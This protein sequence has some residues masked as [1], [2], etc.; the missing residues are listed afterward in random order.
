MSNLSASLIQA[1]RRR[2]PDLPAIGISGYAEDAFRRKL[3]QD[4]LTHFLPKPFNLND[5]ATKVKEVMPRP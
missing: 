2:R 3:G 4:D 5:L 1:V